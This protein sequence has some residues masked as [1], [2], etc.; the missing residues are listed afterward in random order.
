MKQSAC[1]ET[2]V[3][4]ARSSIPSTWASTGPFTRCDL[5]LIEQLVPSTLYLRHEDLYVHYPPGLAIV[6]LKSIESEHSLINNSAVGAHRS[7]AEGVFRWAAAKGVFMWSAT[8]EKMGKELLTMWSNTD[9]AVERRPRWLNL[10]RTSLSLLSAFSSS[11]AAIANL[12]MH[13]TRIA[14]ACDCPRQPPF[15]KCDVCLAYQQSVPTSRAMLPWQ[16]HWCSTMTIC[17]PAGPKTL[18]NACG[19]KR[20]RQMKQKREQEAARLQQLEQQAQ[21][22][23]EENRTHASVRNEIGGPIY[24]RVRRANLETLMQVARH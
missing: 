12:E 14:C 2:H 3:I 9:T 8:K 4:V 21:Q 11:L 1:D 15:S 20:V 24:H 13:D 10:V 23:S 5:Y 7:A 17:W 22:S 16:W 6:V 19:V 18:C